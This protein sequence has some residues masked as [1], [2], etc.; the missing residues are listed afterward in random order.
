MEKKTKNSNV[1]KAGLWEVMKNVKR[2]VQ[3]K[4][5]K[6]NNLVTC[7][8]TTFVGFLRIS[9]IDSPPSPEDR[10]INH[11]ENNH[12]TISNENSKYRAQINTYMHF[13]QLA[14]N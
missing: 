1:S 12:E 4:N 11:K 3:K 9:V 10:V 6:K 13:S 7:S 8:K 5:K 2:S 14:G